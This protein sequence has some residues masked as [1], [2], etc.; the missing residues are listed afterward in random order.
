MGKSLKLINDIGPQVIETQIRHLTNFLRTELKKINA[1]IITDPNP[2]ARSGITV[3][4]YLDT[5]AQDLALVEK[6]LQ[7]KVYISIRYTANIGGI[8]ISTHFFNNEAD[9]LKLIEVLTK[10]ASN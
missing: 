5:P 7:H 1:R 10:C 8:R 3:F 9:I 4:N 2:K 6:I